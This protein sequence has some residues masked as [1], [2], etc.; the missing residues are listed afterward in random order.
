MFALLQLRSFDEFLL[1]KARSSNA[2]ARSKE[3]FYQNVKSLEGC[4]PPGRVN[5][6][7]QLS[8]FFSGLQE[9]ST[10]PSDMAARAV[11]LEQGRALANSFQELSVLSKNMNVDLANLAKQEVRDLNI[12]TSELAN[13]NQQIAAMGST[14]T[15][16]ILDS[17][18][19]LVDK[20]CDIV[21]VTVE[22]SPAGAAK[23]TLGSTGQGPTLVD[24]INQN[25]LSVSIADDRLS[26][27]VVKGAS[28][29]LT[30]QVTSGSLHG[31]G[32]AY[33][34]TAEVMREIDNL[35]FVMVRDMN[36][37]HKQGIDLDGEAGA[38]V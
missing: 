25:N 10:T 11:A 29:F 34:T 26:F 36:A 8:R 27:A 13:L 23:L 4:C 30:S 22:L 2:S 38:V 19:A 14:A 18:D 3:T 12:F 21:G 6:G 33:R 15:N 24:G 7:T 35:A 32:D 1:N 16:S 31:V 28:Q 20:I 37:V 9:I 17:R 5:I